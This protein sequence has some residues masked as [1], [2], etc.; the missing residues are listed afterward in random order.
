MYSKFFPKELVNVYFCIY[1][2]FKPLIYF[3]VFL[4]Y[5]YIYFGIYICFNQTLNQYYKQTAERWS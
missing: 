3:C 2:L 5:L 4:I 1:I